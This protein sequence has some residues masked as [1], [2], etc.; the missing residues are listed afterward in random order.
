MGIKV[1]NGNIIRAQIKRADT[2]NPY[3]ANGPKLILSLIKMIE[4]IE[5]KKR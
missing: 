4:N 3:K 1:K 5:E 2:A